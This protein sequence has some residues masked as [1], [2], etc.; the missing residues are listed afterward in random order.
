M[1]KRIDEM[2]VKNEVEMKIESVLNELK[3]E[4]PISFPPSTTLILIQTSEIIRGEE[5]ECGDEFMK[6]MFTRVSG[7]DKCEVRVSDASMKTNGL[8]LINSLT[9]SSI[10]VSILVTITLVVKDL[11]SSMFDIL[12]S[13]LVMNTMSI[14][15]SLHLLIGRY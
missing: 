12:M 5:D 3:K 11:L 2:R 10:S 15:I 9:S 8:I 13:L 7:E 6:I 1:V 4:D 14:M